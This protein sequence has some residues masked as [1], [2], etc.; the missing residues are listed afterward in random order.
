MKSAA[1]F[2]GT[3]NVVFNRWS[4]IQIIL[5]SFSGGERRE[6]FPEDRVHRHQ[7]GRVRRRWSV[8]AAVHPA[9]VRPKPPARQLHPADHPQHHTQGGR[10]HLSEVLF[11]IGTRL[12]P[13]GL[14]LHFFS[15]EQ[16]LLASFFLTPW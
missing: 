4:H 14:A 9:A 10:H 5:A 8:D 11:S 3:S 13:P 2:Q 15:G 16:L 6:A 1:G 12:E 7:P